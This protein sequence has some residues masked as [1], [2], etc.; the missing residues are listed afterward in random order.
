[1]P[2]PGNS[3]PKA[4]DAAGAQ[5]MPTGNSKNSTGRAQ[6]LAPLDRPLQR[7]RTEAAL[8]PS[9]GKDSGQHCVHSVPLGQRRSL[10][11]DANWGVPWEAR[12]RPGASFD[13]LSTQGSPSF[14][15]SNPRVGGPVGPPCC[16]LDKGPSGA[17]PDPLP[18]SQPL[19]PLGLYVTHLPVS[20][21]TT[22]TPK[23]QGSVCPRRAAAQP[24][25]G[26]CRMGG[27]RPYA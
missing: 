20:Y 11:L 13:S 19:A 8:S 2:A 18:R 15:L 9:P 16:H 1:M 22:W 14:L 12:E 4:W 5:T 6:P 21:P 17:L 25:L 3:G 10:C 27:M 7:P 26:V 23:E 24:G